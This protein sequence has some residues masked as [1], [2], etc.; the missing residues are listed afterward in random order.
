MPTDITT[1]VHASPIKWT[2][3]EW[4]K[5]AV[6]LYQ[7][8]GAHALASEGVNDIKAKDVFEAQ[9]ILPAERRRKQISIAQGFQQIR[10]R[11]RGLFERGQQENLFPAAAPM[12]T[13]AS[14]RGTTPAVGQALSDVPVEES[15]SFHTANR[16]LFAEGQAASKEVS[17]EVGNAYTP[18]ENRAPDVRRIQ[19]AKAS[20]SWKAM[21]QRAEDA[22]RSGSNAL[23]TSARVRENVNSYTSVDDHGNQS[24]RRAS[25]SGS[26]LAELARPFVAMV[27]EE[28]AR[29]L[30][31]TFSGQEVFSNL[32]SR[33]QPAERGAPRHF[34]QVRSQRNAQRPSNDSQSRR[35][36]DDPRVGRIDAIETEDHEDSFPAEVQPLFDP[37]LP[38]S[39]NSDFK[40]MI[41]LVATRDHEYEDLQLLYPQLRFSIVPAE[42]IHGPEV[43]QNCQRVIGLKEEVPRVTE[44]L[45]KRA[46]GYRYVW[47][48][49]GVD[50]VREQLDAWLANPSSMQTGPRSAGPRG[51][52][53]SRQGNGKK[54]AKWP[55]RVA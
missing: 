52:K 25:Q 36:N 43:F 37:K 7:L 16:D 9:N 40:P 22:P 14:G 44:E 27:C 17:D 51:D 2:D 8:K 48:R 13:E 35:T 32:T 41:G 19:E 45:L 55:P 46:L 6:Q 18:E 39:A 12:P 31:Q 26:S 15:H 47:L 10:T 4:N 21:G 53:I 23:N 5:I 28:F 30:V 11:L 1:S 34:G 29:A 33:L 24:T 49:G 54:R 3:D 42:D 38:P 50:R 20:R